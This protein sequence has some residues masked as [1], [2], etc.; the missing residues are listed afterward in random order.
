MS[1]TDTLY[2][3]IERDPSSLPRLLMGKRENGEG[4]PNDGEG[5]GVMLI[6]EGEQ[7]RYTGT[8]VWARSI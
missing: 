8:D 2:A 3:P 6:G 7:D 4:P 5:D 1:I